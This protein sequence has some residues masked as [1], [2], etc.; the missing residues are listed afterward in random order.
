MHANDCN[1]VSPDQVATLLVIP[2]LVSTPP[3]G[4]PWRGHMGDGV[5]AYLEVYPLNFTG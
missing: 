1:R 3:L 5:M 4:M 2:D